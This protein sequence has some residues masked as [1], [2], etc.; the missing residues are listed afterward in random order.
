MQGQCKYEAWHP[1]LTDLVQLEDLRVI[2]SV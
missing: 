1:R 2:A